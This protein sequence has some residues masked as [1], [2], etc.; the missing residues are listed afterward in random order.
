MMA[1]KTER[2][3]TMLDGKHWFTEYCTDFTRISVSRISVRSSGVPR[4]GLEP[5]LTWQK[6]FVGILI[7]QNVSKYSIFN[8]KY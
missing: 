6:F 1:H 7:T 2:T 5:P 8:Q 4:G 3:S